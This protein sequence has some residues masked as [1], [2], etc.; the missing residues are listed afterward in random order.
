LEDLVGSVG[1]EDSG[2]TFGE[3]IKPADG[4]LR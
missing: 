4:E 3:L 2:V 1:L